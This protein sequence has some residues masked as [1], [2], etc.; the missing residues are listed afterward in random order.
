MN[1]RIFVLI[2]CVLFGLSA[3]ESELLDYDETQALIDQFRNNPININRATRSDIYQLPYISETAAELIF[4]R[5]EEKGEINSLDELVDDG[6]LG[7]EEAEALQNCV[8][9]SDAQ[10]YIRT[11]IYDLRFT[12]RLEESRAY[13]D[14]VYLGNRSRFSHKLIVTGGNVSVNALFEKDPGEANYSDNMK[15]NLVFTG[16]MHRV[17]IGNFSPNSVTGM[18]QKEGFV[19]DQYS[20]SGSKN[21]HDF[22]KPSVST[23]DYSGYNG[24]GLYYTFGGT[25]I[26]AYGGVKEISASLNENEEIVSVNLYALTRTLTE[27]ERYHNA[28]HEIFGAGVEGQYLGIRYAAGITEENFDRKLDPAADLREGTAGELS[29]QKSAGDWKFRADAAS[30]LDR[31]NLKLNAQ[32]RSKDITTGFFYGYIQKD[33]FCLSTPGLFLGSGEE[34]HVYGM[35][36]RIRL[37]PKLIVIS[38]N[39]LFTSIL[40]GNSTPGG[41]NS[42]KLSVSF[43]HIMAEPSFSYKFSETTDKYFSLTREEQYQSG[44][45]VKYENKTVT[46]S[47]YITYTDNGKGSNGYLLGSNITSNTGNLKI[48]AGGDIYF[49][50]EGTTVYSAL[51]DIGRFASLTS[52]SGSGSRSYLMVM[53]MTKRFEIGAGISRTV[54]EDSETVGSGYDM[55]NSDAV[56][57][58][59]VNFKLNF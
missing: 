26:S 39:L 15:G 9:F 21:F 17:I 46:S 5:I 3:V 10:K 36:F 2:L 30:D 8:I 19:M 52:F 11:G 53:Y 35:K 1:S 25:R 32:L 50:K 22:L 27:I 24:A 16:G 4:I 7:R 58:A 41:K 56:H 54:S 23:N 40:D 18:L 59:E 34:E 37:N 55:I 33:K 49:T 47:T 20:F 51:A 44:M 12:R 45:K 28:S 43:D 38:E 14:S 29:L 31:F 13:A 6:I 42:V 57:D 48:R